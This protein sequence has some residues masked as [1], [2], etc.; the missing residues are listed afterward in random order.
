MTLVRDGK[1]EG[2]TR[3]PNTII[4]TILC[5]R[6]KDDVGHVTQVC[7][8]PDERGRGIGEVL[9]NATANELSRRH[10]S[11]LTPDFFDNGKTRI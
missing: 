6:V 1:P 10:F 3:R 11:K 9:L 7:L 8:L 4:G 2:R 5:S